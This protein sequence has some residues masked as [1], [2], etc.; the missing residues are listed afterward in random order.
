MTVLSERV[1]AVMEAHWQPEGY[2]V[3]NA[4]VYPFAWLWDSCFHV[5][6]WA[7]L[8]EEDRAVAELAHVFRCQNERTGFVPH[9]DYQRAPDHLRDFWG[10]PNVSTVTQPPMY[11]HAIAELRR[12]GVAVP[13]ELVE[14]AARGV[15]YFLR[16]RRHRSGLVA[17]V[18][19]WETGCDDSPRFDHWGADDVARW[20]D[21]KGALVTAPECVAFD[22]APVSL[23]ALVAWNGAL[24]GLDTSALVDALASRWDAAAQTW[25]D[26]GDGERSSGRSRTLEALLP[27]LV[28][29]ES[30]ALAQITDPDAFGAPF[31]PCSVH[32]A[33]PSFDGR[34]YWRGPVWPQLAYLLWLAG[35]DVA[36]TSVRGASASGLA[37][38][39][40]GDDG[41]GLGAIPQS[42][43][44]LAML[45]EP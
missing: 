7:A 18:H 15:E 9:I 27:L 36:E 10:Q 26:G 30:S 42:W 43:S 41:T 40:D 34:R 11:G 45:M 33:E 28:L 3:P 1:R 23:S 5:V 12:R 14:R 44:G 32:R 8:G 19:P 2:T 29:E 6:I 13:G 21:V 39:W 20:Y 22:C 16:E 24:L 31:G 25:V 17:A 37:E 4:A 35:A 38:Y